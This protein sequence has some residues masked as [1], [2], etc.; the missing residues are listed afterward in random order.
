[1]RAA[2]YLRSSKDRSDVS[3]D[4]QRREL[5]QLAISRGITIAAE[6]ADAVQRGSTEDRPAFR[7]LSVSIRNRGRGWSHLLV[8]DTSRVA[9]GRF[10]AQAF[11]R[12]CAKHGVTV[13][14]RNIPDTDPISR[15]LLESM[16]EAMDE[17]HSLMS[18][19]KG[20]AGMAENVR[21]GFRA[22]GR[23]PLGYRLVHHPTGTLRDGKPVM[24]SQ[25]ALAAGHDVMRGYLSA[26]AAGISRTVAKHDSGLQIAATSLVG[27]EWN[28]LTYAGH[29]VWNRHQELDRH[30]NRTGRRFRPRDEWLITRDTHP[31]LISD[32]QADRILAALETSAVGA[33]VRAAKAQRAGLMLAGLLQTSTGDL[34]TCRGAAHYRLKAD[35]DRRGKLIRAGDVESPV[36]DQVE[37]DLRSDLFVR[38]LLLALQDETSRPG[39]QA[40]IRGEVARLTKQRE[41][42]ARL[43][44]DGD[45]GGVY[46]D[47][48]RQATRQIEALQRELVAVMASENAH[49]DAQ[50]L[51]AADIRRELDQAGVRELVPLVVQR[52]VL[53]ADLTCRVEYGGRCP[54]MAS[55]KGRI[56]GTPLQSPV[57]ILRRA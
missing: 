33:S 50:E 44:A 34:W 2:L 4:A 14:F 53:D 35:G 56:D 52:V 32:L 40:A 48:V 7:E 5:Q 20:L 9:R 21:Q 42:S 3:I 46:M 26:R 43:A 29:T 30:G 54:S 39:S 1:M 18:R 41:R 31:A 12:E 13:V 25:L 11:K 51:T 45:D 15:V 17:V 28:A 16:F 23:A 19:E 36:L 10:I 55:P 38:R 37:R 47:L 24:K 8:L 49:Q 57:R 27:V 6:F 22:G